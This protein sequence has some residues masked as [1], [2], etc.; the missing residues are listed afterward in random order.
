MN[1]KPNV[2]RLTTTALSI[3][4]VWMI[5]AVF[6]TS[7]FYR[8]MGDVH[9]N[10]PV[11]G[12]WPDVITFQI[13]SAL[14]WAFFTPFVIFIAERLPVRKPYVMR[15]LLLLLVITPVL[16]VIRAVAGGAILQFSSGER[17]S[18][19]FARLSL[20]IRFGKWWTFIA[21][22]VIVTNVLLALRESAVRER[23]ATAQQ[24]EAAAVELATLRARVQPQFV[25]STIDAIK[26]RI[27][28]DP[29]GADHTIVALSDLLRRTLEHG[30]RADVTLA[31][32]L[33]LVD[34]YLQL[35]KARCGASLD[36]RFTVDEE[37]LSAR[38]PPLLVQTAL[39]GAMF[40]R[41]DAT[42]RLLAIRGS[43][44]DERLTLEMQYRPALADG[45]HTTA[46]TQARLR[47]IFGDEFAV[48]T[49]A[50]AAST[51]ISIDLPLRFG[52]AA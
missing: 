48:N 16:S 7:E 4:G 44:K 31:D 41:T 38:V 37:L 1:E 6:S 23:R 28:A 14:T 35:E 13:F 3:T 22:I 10:N 11:D 20:D 30:R 26:A 32:E 36:A 43:R 34:R 17:V 19:A 40:G 39:N 15:N 12:M 5:F 8:R 49:T 52:G 50:D 9:S 47:R 33:E 45:E 24:A 46:E 27:D 21:V 18:L 25:L 42:E 29:D 51:L 2:L